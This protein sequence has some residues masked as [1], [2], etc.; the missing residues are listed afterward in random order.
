MR[1]VIL[2]GEGLEHRYVASVLAEQFPDDLK[3][4]IVARGPQSLLAE[5]KKHLKRYSPGQFCSR[6]L[7]KSYLAL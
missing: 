4:V 2:T 1:L 6:V 7:A 5:T 3:A